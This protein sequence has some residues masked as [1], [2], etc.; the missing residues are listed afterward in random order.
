MWTGDPRPDEYR[1]N[2]V[3]NSGIAQS[4]GGRWGGGGVRTQ[5]VKGNKVSRKHL[6]MVGQG[7]VWT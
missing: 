5:R 6:T 7:L 2:R 1:E 3:Q 4:T